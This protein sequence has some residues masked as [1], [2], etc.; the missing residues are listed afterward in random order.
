[1]TPA[2]WGALAGWFLP[3]LPSALRTPFGEWALLPLIFNGYGVR[4]VFAV[5]F[6][7]AAKVIWE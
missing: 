2:M 1:M 5:L 6:G 7:V 3:I 4:F